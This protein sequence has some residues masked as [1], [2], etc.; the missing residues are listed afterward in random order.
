MS[1]QRS[2]GIVKG[3][4]NANFIHHR[5]TELAKDILEHSKEE[6]INDTY[7]E[8]VRFIEFVLGTFTFTV[9]RIHRMNSDSFLISEYLMIFIFAR[10]YLSTSHHA[11]KLC[12]PIRPLTSISTYF[13]DYWDGCRLSKNVPIKN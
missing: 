8:E 2:E 9:Y 11:V 4:A 1:R 3:E 12:Q 10:G 6:R 7:F 13:A 5:V